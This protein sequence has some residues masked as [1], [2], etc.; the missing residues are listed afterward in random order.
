[1]DEQGN[2]SGGIGPYGLHGPEE[3]MN[4]D[5]SR[6]KKFITSIIDDIDRRSRKPY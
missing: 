1:M 3:E 6:N 5:N 4:V 2:R